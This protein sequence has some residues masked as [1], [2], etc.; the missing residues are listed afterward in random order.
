MLPVVYLFKDRTREEREWLVVGLVTLGAL[1]FG[2]LEYRA[3]R[4]RKSGP[5]SLKA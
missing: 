1:V 2:I 3:Y 4:E 5:P